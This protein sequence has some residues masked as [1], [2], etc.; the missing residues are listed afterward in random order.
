MS[1]EFTS[2]AIQVLGSIMLILTIGVIVSAK[3]FFNK[4]ASLD[5][6]T[7]NKD[8]K[9][10]SPLEARNKYPEVDLFR[11]RSFFLEYGL[12][13]SLGIMVL[14]FSW[15]TF[16]EKRDDSSLLLFVSD[17]IEMQ[18]PR[19]A[20][21]PPP[22]PP[23]PAV[24]AMNLVVSDMPDIKSMVFE[25]MSVDANSEVSG[26]VAPMD[27]K[28]Q[29]VAPPPPH[30]PPVNESEREIFRIVE[31]TPMFPGCEGIEGKQERQLCA[32][33]KLLQFIY[34]NITYPQIARENGV[35]GMVVVQFVVERDGSISNITSVR[36]IGAGCGD[37]AIRVVNMM[38][39]WNPGRQRERPVRVMFT[40]PVKFKLE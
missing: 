28:K 17:E 27:S 26:T 10:K 35:E 9:W 24:T 11:F 13:V 39:A 5:L 25:D 40:L 8:K 21:P 23:P 7:L 29:S 1:F 12:L 2:S 37:E 4:Q 6:T 33:E 14:A 34:T 31:Q 38:P 22:P 3:I 30:P 19:T 32:D 15:T 36:D 18:T 16:E 20:E